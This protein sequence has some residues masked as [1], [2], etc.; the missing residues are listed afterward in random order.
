MEMC[1]KQLLLANRPKDIRQ[2]HSPRYGPNDV[3][4]WSKRYTTLAQTL[5]KHGPNIIQTWSKS[6]PHMAHI[7]SKYALTVLQIWSKHVPNMLQIRSTYDQHMTKRCSDYTPNMFVLCSTHGPTVL[8]SRFHGQIF[9][10]PSFT[11]G[12]MC[13]TDG[14]IHNLLSR[15]IG[16]L[17]HVI[18]PCANP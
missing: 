5:S 16:P 10:C 8:A 4:T 15:A 1:H 9:L 18:N 6:A 11:G 17:A 2:T 14:V 13:T 12:L 7:C 3:Q